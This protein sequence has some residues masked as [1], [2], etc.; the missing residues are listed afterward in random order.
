GRG[1]SGF[2]YNLTITWTNPPPPNDTQP[3]VLSSPQAAPASLPSAGGTVILSV[4]AADNVG[5]TTARAE[6]TGP[7]GSKST[8]ALSRSGGNALN[9]TWQGSFTAPANTTTAAQSY[10]AVFFAADAAGNQAG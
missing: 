8:V 10:S 5:V 6:V 7:G 3:P 9:G 4:V 1:G 2:A